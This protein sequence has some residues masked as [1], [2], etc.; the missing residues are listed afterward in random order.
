MSGPVSRG[1][2]QRGAM[3]REQLRG[4]LRHRCLS[5]G[6]LQEAAPNVAEALMGALAGP[7]G[8][9]ATS[10]PDRPIESRPAVQRL[11]DRARLDAIAE[12][13]GLRGDAAKAVAVAAAAPEAID[14]QLLE[15]L[16]DDR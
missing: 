11:I 10:E 2:W 7:D 9:K 13:A 14:Q 4:L 6:E 12:I 5:F 3:D 1:R 15:R 8:G 16:V